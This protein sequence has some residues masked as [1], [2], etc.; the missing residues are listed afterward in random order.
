[1]RPIR[2]PRHLSSIACHSLLSV[3]CSRIAA[4]TRQ[5]RAPASRQGSLDG[6][7]R[8]KTIVSE[9]NGRPASLV[10]VPS[11]L[12]CVLPIDSCA[13]VAMLP[14]ALG[15]GLRRGA[16]WCSQFKRCCYLRID[17]TRA[18]A[19]APDDLPRPRSHLNS[20]LSHIQQ[21]PILLSKLL[22]RYLGLAL[23]CLCRLAVV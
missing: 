7:P 13:L 4:G 10:L 8:W 20:A 9:G 17:L 14:S 12:G 11:G 16:H 19:W 1:M 2:R 5:G 22:C 21:N 23:D 6:W 3:K 15:C 18:R